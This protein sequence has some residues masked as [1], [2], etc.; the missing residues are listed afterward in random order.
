MP[1]GRGAA[2]RVTEV[3]AAENI[4][5]FIWP[6]ANEGAHARRMKSELKQKVPPTGYMPNNLQIRNGFGPGG[7]MR[8][9]ALID[10]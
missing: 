9:H 10:N 1:A 6:R 8:V 5:D 7:R 4:N 2:A 3:S